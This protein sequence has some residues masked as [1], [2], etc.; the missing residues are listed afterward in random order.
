MSLLLLHTAMTINYVSHNDQLS[1]NPVGKEQKVTLIKAVHHE[2][3]GVGG[4]SARK[5]ARKHWK[6]SLIHTASLNVIMKA[7]KRKQKCI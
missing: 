7:G 5:L 4:R 6:T 3:G 2:G 1:D